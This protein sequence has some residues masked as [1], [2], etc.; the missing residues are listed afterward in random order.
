MPMELYVI[1]IAGLAVFG[2]FLYRQVGL[3]GPLQPEQAVRSE[4]AQSQRS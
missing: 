2:A 1:G 4:S 3:Q